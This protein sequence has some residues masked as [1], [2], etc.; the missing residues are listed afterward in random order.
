MQQADRD[1]LEDDEK[2][3]RGIEERICVAVVARV[4]AGGEV[5]LLAVLKRPSHRAING[6]KRTVQLLMLC[7]CV[8][9][10]PPQYSYQAIQVHSI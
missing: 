6:V 1:R 2:L 8:D 7:P 5:L 9:L 3:R 4:V 10:S